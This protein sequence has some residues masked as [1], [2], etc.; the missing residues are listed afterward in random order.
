MLKTVASQGG[1]GQ[2]RKDLVTVGRRGAKGQ[3]EVRWDSGCSA[4]GRVGGG[5]KARLAAE[6]ICS[7]CGTQA[8]R[9]WEVP[10]PLWARREI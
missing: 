7:V 3:K 8:Q 1:G 6:E 5:R 10:V 4:Y 9:C 2:V